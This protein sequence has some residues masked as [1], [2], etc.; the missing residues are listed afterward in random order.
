M[1]APGGA[2]LVRRFRATQPDAARFAEIGQVFL[3]VGQRR[4]A[5]WTIRQY[6]RPTFAAEFRRAGGKKTI[7]AAW[8]Q[9]IQSYAHHFLPRICPSASRTPE[10]R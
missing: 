4:F 9:T 7:I 6:G 1:P 5:F 2:I 10:L 3:G 8:T